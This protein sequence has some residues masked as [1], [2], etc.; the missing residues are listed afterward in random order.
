MAS[1]DDTAI[2]YLTALTNVKCFSIT[3][4][5]WISDG[6][7]FTVLM[8]SCEVFML[9]NNSTPPF[10]WIKIL[11]SYSYGYF[12]DKVYTQNIR[13]V[14]K[15]WFSVSDSFWEF[16]Q[17]LKRWFPLKLLRGFHLNNSLNPKEV[18]LLHYLYWNI[19]ILLY[20]YFY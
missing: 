8:S 20:W 10:R 17:F 1:Q 9:L 2:T 4:S 7:T 3:Y 15:M 18:K 13:C 5:V 11:K 14:C 19:F 16:L 12:S 6:K